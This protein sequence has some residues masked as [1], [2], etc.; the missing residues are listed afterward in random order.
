MLEMD[1]TP[2]FSS[3]QIKNKLINIKPKK[4]IKLVL[5]LLS[6]FSSSSARPLA[7]LLVLKLLSSSSSSSARPQ[8]PQLVLKLLSSSSSSSARL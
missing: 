3:A 7:P 8:V 1:C 6:S 5:K 4:P 2:H